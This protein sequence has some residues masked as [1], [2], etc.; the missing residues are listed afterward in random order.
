MRFFVVRLKERKVE[1]AYH[2]ECSIDH[3][4]CHW[5]ASSRVSK[6]V[7]LLPILM[8]VLSGC[9]ITDPATQEYVRGLQAERGEEPNTDPVECFTKAIKIDPGRAE[10]YEARSAHY[11]GSGR[12]EL[13]LKDLDQ[14]ITL[15]PSRAYLYYERGLCQCRLRNA[16]QALKDFQTAIKAQPENK[17]FYSGLALAYLCSDNCVEALA[18]IE[19]ALATDHPVSKWKYQRAV[20]LGRQGRR[21][22]SVEQFSN[23]IALTHAATQN[24]GS[25]DVFFEGEREYERTQ[26][27]SIAELAAEWGRAVPVDYYR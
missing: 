11:V 25:R 27:M 7:F 18:A 19:K 24:H 1:K 26:K 23:T 14:A 22:E 9:I 2:F 6:S 20:I 5:V 4:G 13:A 16:E 10:F 15:T 12:L 8:I 21:A 17:Q 3:A